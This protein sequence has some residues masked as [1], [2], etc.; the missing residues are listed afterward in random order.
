MTATMTDEKELAK[1]EAEAIAAEQKAQ[2]IETSIVE[3]STR[4]K[5]A[6]LIAA[7]HEALQAR[8][9]F[10]ATAKLYTERAARSAEIDRVGEIGRYQRLIVERFGSH[11]GGIVAAFDDAL[12]ALTA[13]VTA[14]VEHNDGLAEIASALRNLGELPSS[15]EPSDPLTMS[16]NVI[17]L[18]DIDV[19]LAPID[20][21]EL[22]A[23]AAYRALEA[24]GQSTG[25]VAAITDT[26]PLISTD[27][28]EAYG[29]AH[30]STWGLSDQLRRIAKTVSDREA[31]NV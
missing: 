21:A 17:R 29:V 18:A 4:A 24:A 23:D 25:K 30:G 12:A 31:S 26:G 9:L 10:D 22:V 5:A 28:A 16:G 15:I 1:L 3:G 11:E 14:S 27:R 2:A 19:T 6:D 13:M 7:E 8:A 20:V